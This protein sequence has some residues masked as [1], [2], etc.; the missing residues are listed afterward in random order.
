MVAVSAFAQAP[1]RWRRRAS[2]SGGIGDT[3]H[4]GGIAAST[5]AMP[6]LSLIIERDATLADAIARDFPAFG[7]KPHLA[8]GCDAGP[9]P[10]THWSFDAVVL[11][12]DAIGASCLQMLRKLQ[13][14][15]RIPLM[16]LSAAKDEQDQIEILE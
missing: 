11:D 4:L 9:R 6:Y 1:G 16:L 3:N 8:A 12:A 14:R 10:L 5:H 2:P 15:S 13:L 7:F